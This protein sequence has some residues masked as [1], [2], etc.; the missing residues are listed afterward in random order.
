M[1]DL[2]LNK[3]QKTVHTWSKVWDHFTR[4]RDPRDEN[5]PLAQQRT[6]QVQCT[7]CIPPI[8]TIF[9]WNGTT[10][11]MNDHLYSLNGP[12]KLTKPTLTF[13]NGEITDPQ[14][15]SKLRLD[16][17]LL[18]FLLTSSVAFN[19]LV[20]PHFLT[21]I[22]LLNKNYQVPSPFVMS[23]RILESRIRQGNESD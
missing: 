13:D 16:Q 1:C 11:H 5:L 22:H 6:I 10:S 4:I 9:K 18:A 12:H 20:N 23:N 21:F 8:I 17:T 14:S 2:N 7:L 19:V 15:L 3:K